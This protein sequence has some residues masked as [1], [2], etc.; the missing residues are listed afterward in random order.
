MFS[1]QEAFFCLADILR[2]VVQ[3]DFPVYY[4]GMADPVDAVVFKRRLGLVQVACFGF[5]AAVQVA[6]E[7]RDAEEASNP[8]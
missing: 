6:G 1:L 5:V 4:C 3:V 7:G 2:V 8:Q